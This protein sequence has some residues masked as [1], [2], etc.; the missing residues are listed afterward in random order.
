MISTVPNVPR[1]NAHTLSDDDAD[2]MNDAQLAYFRDLLLQWKKDLLKEADR[3]VNQ[4]QDE[5]VAFPDPNDRATQ[6]EELNLE[7]RTRERERKLLKKINEALARLDTH[8]YGYCEICGVEIGL[9][10]LKARP[11]ATLCIDCKTLQEIQ[12]KQI[13]G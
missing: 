2:Y 11:T 10:R 5:A 3:T 12:E 9:R 6:E 8:D 1:S 4:M 7:L 13:R